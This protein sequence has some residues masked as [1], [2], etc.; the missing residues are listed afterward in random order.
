[1]TLHNVNALDQLPKKTDQYHP[2][3]TKNPGAYPHAFEIAE[4]HLVTLNAMTILD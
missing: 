2:T 4:Q 3:W 1:M